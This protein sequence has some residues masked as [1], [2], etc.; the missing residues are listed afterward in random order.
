MVTQ[1]SGS[2]PQAFAGSQ[3][4]AAV[5]LAALSGLEA[6]EG[7]GNTGDLGGPEQRPRGVATLGSNSRRRS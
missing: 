4:G 5:S 3:A 6:S 1:S 2:Q 7:A